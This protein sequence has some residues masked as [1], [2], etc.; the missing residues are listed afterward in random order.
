M[1]KTRGLLFA[2]VL[3]IASAS[4]G[5][6]QQETSQPLYDA[7]LN[8]PI[9]IYGDVVE[10]GNSYGMELPPGPPQPEPV[11]SPSFYLV[12]N[13]LLLQYDWNYNLL[14]VT[15]LPPYVPWPQG[16]ATWEDSFF[17]GVRRWNAALSGLQASGY[18][19]A[20]ARAFFWVDPLEQGVH[21]QLDVSNL[22][23][24]TEITLNLNDPNLPPVAAPAVVRLFKCAPTG[25]RLSGTL[26]QG[27]IM[28]RD[29]IGWLAG[30][31]VP[32]LIQALNRGQG[33]VIVHTVR[34][35][36]GELMGRIRATA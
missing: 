8:Y 33:S 35:P 26:A 31:R 25:A 36:Q 3:L 22:Q 21:F 14:N 11:V 4:A 6:A 20:S 30:Y 18:T 24:V 2:V 19:D 15:Q 32:D 9:N 5:L 28:D 27:M 23:T 17:A 7:L 16:G 13:G 12:Q 34:R 1:H 29:L 10:Q